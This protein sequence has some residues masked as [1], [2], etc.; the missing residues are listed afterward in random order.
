[1]SREIYWLFSTVIDLY[2]WVIIMGVVLSWLVAFNVINVH[3]Q[4]VRS[5]YAGFTSLTEPALRPIRNMLPNLRG[6][7]ISP[8]I[9]IIGLLF[10]E[11]ILFRILVGGFTPL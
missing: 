2:V 1:M 3:N 10:L 8:I 11:R 4:F 5:L 9:L 7:D 6:F